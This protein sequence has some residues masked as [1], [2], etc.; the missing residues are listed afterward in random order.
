MNARKLV[1]SA[2][3]TAGSQWVSVSTS[4]RFALYRTMPTAPPCRTLKPFSTRALP[5]RWHATILPVK[6]PGGAGVVQSALE[7]GA[8]VDSTTGAGPAPSVRD[9]PLLVKT[10][11]LDAVTVSVVANSRVCVDAA[12][13]V[14]HGDKWFTVPAPGPSFPADADTKTPAAYASRNASSTGSLNGSVPPDIEKLMTS[15]PSSMACPTAAAESESKQLCGPQTLYAMTYAPGAIPW[16]SGRSVPRI[17][18]SVTMSPA[19]VEAVWVPWPLLS[20][21]R[22]ANRSSP[23]SAS[24]VAVN[25]APPISLLV[26]TK[27]SGA[28]VNG[29]SPKLHSRAGPGGAGK[30]PWSAKDGCSGHTPV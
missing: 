2:K 29:L 17:E 1:P 21:A 28:G 12:T 20:R 23:S 6:V 13:D 5:P 18:T 11:P 10:S 25:A 16:M 4:A 26:Q 19:A 14:T 24:Y 9:A 3:C 8:S 15:T 7:Y 27:G 30:L 22:P